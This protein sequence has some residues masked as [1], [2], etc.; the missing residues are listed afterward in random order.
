VP[1]LTGNVA[2]LR[3]ENNKVIQLEP[4]VLPPPSTNKKKAA[5][6]N[7]I[8]TAKKESHG[9]FSKVGTFFAAIFH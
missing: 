9:F 3:L 2:V 8:Q 7:N 6:A 1:D 5:P 4:L